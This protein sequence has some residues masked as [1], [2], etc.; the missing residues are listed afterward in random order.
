MR[1]VFY[2]EPVSADCKLKTTDDCHSAE[3]KWVTNSE[4]QE[5]KRQN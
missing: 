3:A 1:V 2:A 5:M 4:L